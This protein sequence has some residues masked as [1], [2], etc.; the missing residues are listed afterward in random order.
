MLRTAISPSGPDQSTLFRRLRASIAFAVRRLFP[1]PHRHEWHDWYVF[2]S[3]AQTTVGPNPSFR[4]VGQQIIMLC[5]CGATKRKHL[6]TWGDAR[7]ARKRL[8]YKRWGVGRFSLPVP[9]AIEAG[10]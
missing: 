1:P 5:A 6:A 9:E 10:Q 2:D 3:S 8:P 4:V 7:L